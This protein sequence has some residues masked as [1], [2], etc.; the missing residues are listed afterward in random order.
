MES[1]RDRILETALRLFARDGFEATSTSAI[2]GELGM[3]KSA[4]YKHFPDKR[5]ILDSLVEEMLEQH[6]GTGAARGL[7]I[8]S[9]E[10]AARRYASASPDEMADLGQTLFAHWT[11][12]DSAVAFRRMLS[13]ERFRDEQVA[14]TYDELFIT[15]PLNYNEMLFAEMIKLGAL[16][17]GDAAQMALDFWAP[18]YLLMQATDGAMSSKQAL[19]AIRAHVLAFADRS[20]EKGSLPNSPVKDRSHDE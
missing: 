9:A 8:G 6:R 7:A 11:A 1:T 4:L 17:P 13:L 19:K 10:E 16:K 2:A 20:G 15:G 3:A 12:D 18:I 14:R 5:A